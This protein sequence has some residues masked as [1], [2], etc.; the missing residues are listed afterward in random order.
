MANEEE[1]GG[2]IV[3][4]TLYNDR[5]S[6][7]RI[8]NLEILK[9][10]VAAEVCP[11]VRVERSSVH[12]NKGPTLFGRPPRGPRPPLI[13]CHGLYTSAAGWHAPSKGTCASLRRC[14]LFF[15]SPVEKMDQEPFTNLVFSPRRV[16]SFF[17]YVC[18]FVEIMVLEKSCPPQL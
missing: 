17:F 9:E 13:L 4:V 11:S 7:Q 15:F 5:R 14:S 1:K 8:G 18:G 2:K 16:P 3:F 10:V 6:I 12:M